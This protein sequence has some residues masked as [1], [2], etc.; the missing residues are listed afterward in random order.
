MTIK[1]LAIVGAGTMGTGIAIGAVSAGISTII[2]DSDPAALGRAQGRVA[3]FLQ[4]RHEK[5][6]ISEEEVSSGLSHLRNST[7]LAEASAGDLVIEAVFEDIQVK[8]R[9][10]QNLSKFISPESIVATNTSCLRVADLATAVA[11]PG[12]FLGLHY[13]SP[14]EINPLVE[15]ISGPLTSDMTI[16]RI[17]PFL[18]HTEKTALVCRDSNGFVVNRFFCPYSN[19]AARCLDDG[20]GTSGQIDVIARDTFDLAVG[21][22]AVMDIIKPRINLHA[23]RNL[24]SHGPFYRPAKSL[25]CVGNDDR[26]WDI[27]GSPAELSAEAAEAIRD[28]LMGALFLPVLQ[29]LEEGVAQPEDF[30][31]G[32]RLALRFGRPPVSLMR[33][34]GK[35]RVQHA[36]EAAAKK[37]EVAVPRCLDRIVVT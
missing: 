24:A 11:H 1:T 2:I 37:Y 4:R 16:E 7:D 8:Q 26:N 6:K 32:A 19:E 20:L 23:V 15:V 33:E 18:R 30:D 12:R 5:G 10:F 21:P 36:V 28:R 17:R 25:I 27:E 34:I 14:A 22:F 3:G 13:F 9:L 35:A 31:T 29:A